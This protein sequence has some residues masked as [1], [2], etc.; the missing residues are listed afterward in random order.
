ML[1]R[2]VHLEKFALN[3]YYGYCV[4]TTN[5]NL[6]F[7]N[8]MD[9]LINNIK[10]IHERFKVSTQPSCSNVLNILICTQKNMYWTG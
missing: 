1:W 10:N 6:K 8:L 4:I 7:E 9:F 2:K 3:K 5:K